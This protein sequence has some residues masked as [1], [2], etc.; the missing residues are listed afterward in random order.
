MNVLLSATFAGSAATWH[1]TCSRQR[2]V[3]PSPLPPIGYERRRP[4]ETVP[5]RYRLAYDADLRTAVLRVFVRVITGH[6]RRKS[7]QRGIVDPRCGAITAIQRAGD[8]LRLNLHFHSAFLDGVYSREDEEAPPRFHCLPLADKDVE[9]VVTTVRRRVLRLLVRRGL[10]ADDPH[11]DP[12]AGVDPL[13]EQQPL[14]AACYQAAVQGRIA[15]GERAGAGVRRQGLSG[16][17][18]AKDVIRKGKLSA[19][20]DGFDLH[21]NTRIKR[22]RRAD[23]ER[24]CRYMLRPPIATERLYWRTPARKELVVE[25]KR[26]RRDGTTALV[27]TPME[28]IEKLVPLIP[29][30]NSNLVRYH[31]VLAPGSKWRK[32]IVATLAGRSSDTTTDRA[33]AAGT[34]AGSESLDDPMPALRPRRLG[35]AQLLKRVLDVDGLTCRRCQSSRKIIAFIQETSA[36]RQI[37]QHVGLPHSPPPIAPARPPPQHELEFP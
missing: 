4:E 2:L 12:A 23:L 33:G 29:A 3:P 18:Q 32:S 20:L 9:R 7:K 34:G 1:A 36:A 8:G 37:L 26:S 22:H 5:L 6:Y 19:R 17:R 27:L 15:T 13:Q 30:K 31:G 16:Q 21:A 24:L 28:L 25:L 35:W 10:V 14:L 11:Q